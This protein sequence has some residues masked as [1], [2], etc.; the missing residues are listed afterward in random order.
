MAPELAVPVAAADAPQVPAPP[1]GRKRGRTLTQ[2]ASL[3][4]FAS[5]LDYGVKI[6]VSLVV[7]PILVTSLGR[8]LYG[9]WEMLA[10]LGSYMSATDGRPTEALRLIIAQRQA[11]PDDVKRRHV[12]EALLVWLIMLPIVVTA[13]I[14]LAFWV[15]PALTRVP[16][17]LVGQVRI[18]TLLIGAT[19]VLGGLASI[20][21]SVLRGMNLGYR[22]M[23]LQASL[24]VLGGAC[25]AGFVWLGWGLVGL[26]EAQIIRALVTIVV[27]YLLVRRYVPW[28]GAARPTRGGVKSLLGMSVWLTAGDAIAKIMLASDVLILGAVLAPAAVTT[29][30]LT[31]Y[32]ARTATGIHVFAAGAAIPGLGGLLG[33]RQY[34]R[35]AL[36]RRE[37]LLMTWLFATVIGA[38]ILLWNRSFITL[39]VGSQNYAGV[40]VDLLLVAATVQTVFIRTD[41][42]VIDATLRPRERVL[43]GA[44][45]AVLT[46]GL[47]LV[48]TRA[49]G[50]A[51]LCAGVLA[52]RLVQTIAY[53]VLVR[54]DL[55]AASVAGPGPL[56]AVRKPAA[57]LLLFAAA[58]LL[59]QRLAAPNWILWAAGIAASLVVFAAA[60]LALGPTGT[61]RQSLI[62]RLRTLR[63]GTRRS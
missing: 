55:G 21:E 26:G 45:A 53:P 5:L 25:A 8:T 42:Y 47:S 52:G 6:L 54:R 14:A 51:G 28:F 4:A 23:G 22:R 12:G 44:V 32:A 59:G 20:P 24:N 33:S 2:R 56:A 10:K 19:F 48:L 17:E 13:G 27:F 38:V 11:D 16:P 35:A 3:T 18:A 9:I 46:I 50:L 31:G 7:T 39:W 62:G 49:F 37:L 57:T 61:E 1:A 63:P 34:R 30:A 41:A 43:V 40:L 60:A 36:A 58:A 15:A 29:Y